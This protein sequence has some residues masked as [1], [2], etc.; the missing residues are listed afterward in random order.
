MTEPDRSWLQ[1][2][3][4]LEP[5]E[6]EGEMNEEWKAVWVAKLDDL[7]WLF[8]DEGDAREFARQSEQHGMR[9]NILTMV[10][11]PKGSVARGEIEDEARAGDSRG[12]HA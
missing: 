8:E 12:E 6:E 4:P 5:E 11:H 1:F 7:V 2:L 10:V 3:R 9:M